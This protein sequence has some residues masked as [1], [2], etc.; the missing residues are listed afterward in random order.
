MREERSFEGVTAGNIKGSIGEYQSPQQK[1]R[2]AKAE[3]VRK[4]HNEQALA[5]LQAVHEVA[6]MEGI[7]LDVKFG[8]AGT[9]VTFKLDERLV[10][11]LIGIVQRNI[12][13]HSRDTL[14]D[15]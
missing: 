8:A 15:D 6:S 7:P 9:D 2:K 11:E 10:V 3:A 14:F 1:I 13:T 4:Q 5:Q 12:A